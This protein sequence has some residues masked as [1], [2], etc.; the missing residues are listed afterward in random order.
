MLPANLGNLI[1]AC[2][3]AQKVHGNNGAGLEPPLAL[4]ALNLLAQ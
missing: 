3:V 4:D 2:G 1:K